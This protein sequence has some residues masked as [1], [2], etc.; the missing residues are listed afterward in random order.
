MRA[1]IKNMARKVRG[2]AAAVNGS[3]FSNKRIPGESR[4][5]PIRSR[6]GCNVDPGFRRECSQINVCS[7]ARLTAYGL[8]AFGFSQ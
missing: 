5:P 8:A 1:M 6:G 4:D 7:V 2:G 3:V